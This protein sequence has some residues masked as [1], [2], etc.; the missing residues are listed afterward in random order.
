ML[1]ARSWLRAIPLAA[2]LFASPLASAPAEAQSPAG[3][4]PTISASA[5]GA[6][7]AAP[8]SELDPSD[9][10]APFQVRRGNGQAAALMVVGGIAFVL[11]IVVGGGPGALMMV[12]GAAAGLYGLYL[13]LQ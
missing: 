7:R 9:A 6:R 8:A 1:S 12:G 5:A 3:A 2:A 10:T 11:G 13:Y 4:G